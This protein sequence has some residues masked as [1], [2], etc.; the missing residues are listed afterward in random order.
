LVRDL[1][2]NVRV[3][4]GVSDAELRWIYAR[5]SALVAP[6]LEDYGLTPLEAASFGVPTL[7]LAAGGYLDTV[8]PGLSGL[9]FPEP[10]PAAVKAA[11]E[12][13]ERHT[14]SP[15]AIR[16]HA[17]RFSQE[18]FVAALRSFVVEL[19]EQGRSR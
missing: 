5:A 6:S 3:V 8:A 17:A 19:I 1:P 7:A 18:Q 9:F 10:T 13:G 11:V 16:A 15:E 14:W 4:S 2:A 12:A